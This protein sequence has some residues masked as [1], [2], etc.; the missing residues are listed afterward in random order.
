MEQVKLLSMTVVL[1]A[2]IWASA[3]SLVNEAVTVSVTFEVVPA[4]GA[5]QMLIQVANPGKPY[6]LEI[7]G[8][9]KTVEAVQAQAPLQVRLRIPDRPTT[10]T[11]EIRLDRAV[12]KQE[13]AERFAE[14]RKLTIVS[15]HP[16]SLP[17]LVDHW[18]T[19]EAAI[20]LRRLTLAYD[21]EP[22]LQR[23]SVAVKMRK[24][25]LEKRP[26]GQP[27]QID[28]A[29]DLERLLQEMPTGES[30]TIAVTLD[31]LQFGPGAELTPG[32][33]DVTATV[34]AQRSTVQI[35]TV[36]ILVAVSFANLE[37]PYRAVT[38][39]GD[40]LTLVTRTITVT[41]PTDQVNRLQRGATR[42][43]GII[44]LKE[45]DLDQLDELKLLT[46]EYHLPEDLELAHEPGPIQFKLIRTTAAETQR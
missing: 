25:L 8:P 28:I 44:Q 26:A 43:Y 29:P 27:L 42:A 17:V 1:T 38:R 45:A 18:V 7:S 19:K 39:A 22:Q 5:P 23:T 34:K 37:K 6:E 36:P 24:S 13:L 10:G 32:T 16:D 41:G 9:R 35:P 30:A 40:P 12:L 11:D 3:D 2:L 15:V 46:P 20:V 4:A 14:F 31:G 21:V 33:I